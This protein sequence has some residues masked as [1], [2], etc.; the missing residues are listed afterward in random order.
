VWHK[1]C[2]QQ[3]DRGNPVRTAIGWRRKLYG[4]EN[5][6]QVFSNNVVQGSCAGIMKCAMGSIHQQLP[7]GAKIVA[8]I[9]DE[10]LCECRIED[11]EEVLGIV[12]GEMEDA[13]R[14]MVGD[15]VVLKAEGGIVASWGD[16]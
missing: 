15:A 5:R 2:Q 12:V 14:P 3:V 1:W 13:A 7:A 8:V 16:K 10:L 11:A 6:V 4:E 9:H